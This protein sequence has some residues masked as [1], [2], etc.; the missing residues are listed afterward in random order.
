[1]RP[2]LFKTLAAAAVAM[3]APPA[4]ATLSLIAPGGVLQGATGVSVGAQTLDVRFAPGPC[5]AVF[6]ECGAVGGATMLFANDPAGALQAA[7]ALY[8]EVGIGKFQSSGANSITHILLTGCTGN[9]PPGAQC[10]ILTPY[11]YNGISDFVLYE[12][13]AVVAKS[14]GYNTP[15]AGRIAASTAGGG[16][17]TWAV[18]TALPE[19]V[20]VP[21]PAT[22]AVL[23]SAA[24][25]LAG[26]RLGRTSR[27]RRRK[28]P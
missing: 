6:V 19:P 20:A 24:A 13:A 26:A 25:G 10:Q 14:S 3:G 1:M 5:D 12:A 2:H 9:F 16:R 23:L 11:Q 18:W 8:A 27:R 7:N 21:E 22:S 28:Q 15:V 4:G 17:T